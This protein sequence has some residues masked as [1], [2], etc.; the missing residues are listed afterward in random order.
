MSRFEELDIEDS[1]ELKL[2][3][4]ARGPLVLWDHFLVAVHNCSI[5]TIL[6]LWP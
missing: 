2:V 1:S 4:P 3:Y 6:V 5:A